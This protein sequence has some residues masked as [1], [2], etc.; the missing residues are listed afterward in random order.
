MN[1]SMITAVRSPLCALG[2]TGNAAAVF[3]DWPGVDSGWRVVAV[4]L[5][6][7][8]GIFTGRFGRVY[9]GSALAASAMGA[10]IG[11]LFCSGDVARRTLH[12][13]KLVAKWTCDAIRFAN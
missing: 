6:S 1:E 10:W 4:Q 11:E 8:V 7:V 13:C 5:R 3:G 2:G 9:G 12:R